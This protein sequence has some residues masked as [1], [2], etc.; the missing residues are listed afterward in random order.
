MF[1]SFPLTHHVE[2]VAVLASSMTSDRSDPLSRRLLTRGSW[3]ETERLAEILRRETVG[4]ILLL[5]AAG[6]AVVW[7]NSPWSDGYRAISDFAIGPDSCAFALSVAAWAADGLLAIFFFV[8][9]LELKREF[10]AG[11]L[12][13]P[14]RAA[15]PI[16]AAVGGMIVPAAVFVTV[17]LTAGEPE[18]STVGRCPSPRISPSR[19]PCLRCCPRTCRARCARFC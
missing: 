8:V 9:G 3:P 18:N 10:V 1:D 16:A 19:W 6:V 13:D 5:A 12:R 15:V 17:I 14:A 11:D 7:A 2:S 4:G